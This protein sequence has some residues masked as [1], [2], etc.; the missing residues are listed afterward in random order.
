LNQ[1][2]LHNDMDEEYDTDAISLTSTVE[3]ANDGIYDIKEIRSEGWGEDEN[4]RKVMKY[5]IEW[6][7]YPLHA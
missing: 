6:D 3:S 7:N 1:P 4:G 2:T 5:L